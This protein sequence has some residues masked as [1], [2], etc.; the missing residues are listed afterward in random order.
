M[1]EQRQRYLALSLARSRCSINNSCII[2]GLGSHARK[3]GTSIL[4][5]SHLVGPGIRLTRHR[6]ANSSRCYWAEGINCPE[7][8]AAPSAQDSRMWAQ[9]G[10]P[11]VFLLPWRCVLQATAFNLQETVRRPPGPAGPAALAVALREQGVGAGREAVKNVDGAI[12]GAAPAVWHSPELAR[13]RRRSPRPRAPFVPG[14]GYVKAGGRGKNSGNLSIHGAP[15]ASRCEMGEGVAD[16]SSLEGL[17]MRIYNS[18]CSGRQT[19]SLGSSLLGCETSGQPDSI[20]L[21]IEAGHWFPAPQ[22]ALPNSNSQ[23]I[24]SPNPH[25]PIC[26]TSPTY[27]AVKFSQ[28]FCL[29]LLFH[30]CL[31]ACGSQ[32]PGP[33]PKHHIQAWDR[34]WI[35]VLEKPVSGEEGSLGLSPALPFGAEWIPGKLL[36]FLS[37]CLL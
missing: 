6:E 30:S 7:Q 9:H 32:F 3:I 26:F 37:C 20:L 31:V 27:K 1:K 14:L 35:E 28:V 13:A 18:A 15:A 2:S 24:L 8:R 4:Q 25:F 29:F 11:S 5:G 21:K 36:T 22:P 17:E 10:A 34:A 12:W 23:V 19:D 16:S 33:S